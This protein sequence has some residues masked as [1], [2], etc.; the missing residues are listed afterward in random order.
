MIPTGNDSVYI[1]KP[2]FSACR[3]KHLLFVRLA[4]QTPV[5]AHLY[6]MQVAGRVHQPV[7]VPENRR[8][9]R[10]QAFSRTLAARRRSAL[11]LRLLEGN[12]VEDRVGETRAA[13]SGAIV[14]VETP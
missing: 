7:C 5:D 6:P 11:V 13:T 10:L 4:V 9:L 2:S 3:L 12:Q 8:S 1:G 14:S